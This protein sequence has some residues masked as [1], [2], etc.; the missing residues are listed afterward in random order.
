MPIVVDVVSKEDF[1]VWVAAKQKE[2][3]IAPEAEKTS[4]PADKA[5]EKKPASDI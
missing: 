3:G 5:D 2:A 4:V 1:A